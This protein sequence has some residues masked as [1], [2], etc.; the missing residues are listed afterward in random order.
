MIH[1]SKPKLAEPSLTQPRLTQRKL[2]LPNLI[3]TPTRRP[4]INDQEKTGAPLV[5]LTRLKSPHISRNISAK[6]SLSQNIARV[7]GAR[8]CETRFAVAKPSPK[9][10]WRR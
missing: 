3:L 9:K 5:K 2:V 4:K 1:L 10:I 6:N 8:K 7:S